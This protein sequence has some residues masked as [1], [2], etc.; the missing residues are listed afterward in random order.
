MK[1]KDGKI[2]Y[3]KHSSTNIV[4]HTFQF[5]IQVLKRT[6]HVLHKANEAIIQ[7]ISQSQ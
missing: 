5:Y 7:F 3:I 6:E 1:I 4:I 2:Q